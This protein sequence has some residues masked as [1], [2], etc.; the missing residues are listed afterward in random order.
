MEKEI[1]NDLFR[2]TNYTTVY[3]DIKC[4]IYKTIIQRKNI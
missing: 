3:D 2:Y 1:Q 4:M